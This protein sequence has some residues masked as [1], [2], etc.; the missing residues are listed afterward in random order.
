MQWSNFTL[1]YES[2]REKK[3]TGKQS[4][5]FEWWKFIWKQL[6]LHSQFNSLSTVSFAERGR[7]KMHFMSW[8]RERRRKSRLGALKTQ[9]PRFVLLFSSPLFVPQNVSIT[10]HLWGGANIRWETKSRIQTPVPDFCSCHA[11]RAS[12]SKCLFCLS[13]SPRILS[14]S[15]FFAV[16]YLALLQW[17]ILTVRSQLV[18]VEERRPEII[19]LSSPPPP[20]P[21]FLPS[22]S[23]NSFLS[24]SPSYHQIV[25]INVRGKS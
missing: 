25:W 2:T 8:K 4:L 7:E 22:C 14:L 24:Y 13:L 9:A 20:P 16:R 17:I 5:C 10:L 15:L 3:N 6:L 19:S 18:S 12:S 23:H 21:P 1:M 11:L